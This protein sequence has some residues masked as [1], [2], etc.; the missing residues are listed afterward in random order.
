VLDK[1][2]ELLSGRPRVSSPNFPE[3][4][5]GSTRRMPKLT[6]TLFVNIPPEGQAL[7]FR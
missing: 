4:P 1:E 7:V 3:R 2:V 5:L 6:H